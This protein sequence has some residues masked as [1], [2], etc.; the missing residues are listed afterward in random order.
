M[1]CDGARRRLR[2]HHSDGTMMLRFDSLLVRLLVVQFIVLVLTFAAM[3]F[4][5]GQ[6]RNTAAARMVV[7]LWVDALYRL[8]DVPSGTE[9][10]VP[11]IA[12][13]QG[14]P[15]VTARVARAARF[16][17]LREEFSQHGITVGEIRVSR[18]GE[19]ETTWLET[20]DTNNS[21]ARARWVG[22]DGLAY[23]SGDATPRGALALILLSLVLIASI[24][25][26]WM[27]VRP[28]GA[29]Q[30]AMQTYRARG[31]LPDALRQKASSGPREVRALTQSFFDFTTERA[32]LDED[33]SLML[34]SISHDLRSP[35]ARIRLHA[36]LMPA[37]SALDETK[38][39]IIRNVDIADRHLASFLDFALPVAADER[40]SISIETLMNEVIEASVDSRGSVRI[41]RDAGVANIVS[42]RRVLLRVLIAGLENASKYG[43]APILFRAFSRN[44]ELAF[45]IEDDGDG[46]ALEE[47]ARLMRPFERGQQ[48]RTS[49]GT[50]LGLAFADQMAKRIGGR[51]EL[52]QHTRGLIFRCVLP[53]AL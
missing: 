44:G 22:F 41:E 12:A 49:P 6:S 21:S 50:G 26:T 8:G 34:A 33:R 11:L 35:L 27:V 4:T 31:V 17:S 37:S 23:K 36:D 38:E 5:V 30:A 29:L 43:R 39:A 13:R 28:L 45:E 24:G 25:L 3:I 48:S 20:I 1:D 46:I 10:P 53:R 42:S 47:R 18:V 32:R 15:P 2:I 51:V 16:H 7:P 40:Q 9:K 52:D 14:V 19:I